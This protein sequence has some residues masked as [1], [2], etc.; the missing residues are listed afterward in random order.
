MSTW[1]ADW[2]TFE[3]ALLHITDHP[4]QYSQ[5][6]W[7]ARDECGTTRCVAGWVAH[8]G[9]W[10][11]DHEDRFVWRG[12]MRTTISNAAMEVLTGT[13]YGELGDSNVYVN[14]TLFDAGLSWDAILCNVS[15]MAAHDGHELHARLR[16]QLDAHVC[17]LDR[18]AGELHG[19]H[20]VP[21]NDD[22]QDEVYDDE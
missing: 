2:P 7:F 9:G 12:D 13:I 1:I 18:D 16:S 20:D 15:T 21:D 4:E 11:I 10:E 8:F 3:A 19:Y 5:A 14:D 6:V 22:D 17:I